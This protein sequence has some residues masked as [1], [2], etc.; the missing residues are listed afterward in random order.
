[1][2]ELKLDIFIW[3]LHPNFASPVKFYIFLFSVTK[4]WIE[5][6]TY[7]KLTKMLWSL[8]KLQMC[9]T[10]DVSLRLRFTAISSRS[11]PFCIAEEKEDFLIFF[12][13]VMLFFRKCSQ[14]FSFSHIGILPSEGRNPGGFLQWSNCSSSLFSV[15]CCFLQN[16]GAKLTRLLW[17][18]ILFQHSQFMSIHVTV[19]KD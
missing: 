1:M 11:F 17:P 18:L 12:L 19:C 3:C 16:W 8:V 14:Y 10:P 7:W 2:D 9:K 13:K 6:H 5:K 4:H 15:M